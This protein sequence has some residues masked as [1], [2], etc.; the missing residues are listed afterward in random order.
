MFSGVRL[1]NFEIRV[2]ADSEDLG[3][4]P[5]CY[6]Q[7][8]SVPE[9]ATKNFS[10]TRE[11]YGNWVSVNKSSIDETDLVQLREVRVYGMH[12]ECGSM[13]LKPVL[14]G[15]VVTKFEGACERGS[16]IPRPIGRGIWRTVRTSPGALWHALV[17]R[18]LH[19]KL[20]VT[21]HMQTWHMQPKSS[22]SC[23]G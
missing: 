4:N 12:G 14:H 10:C 9:G 5:I 17:T 16:Q 3:N 7:Q 2:G 19:T 1:R 13:G 22:Q 15:F 20:P 21:W 11:L 6:E 18:S 8:S 23:Y